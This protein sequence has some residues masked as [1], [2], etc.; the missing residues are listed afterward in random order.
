MKRFIYAFLLACLP[1]I[2]HA[3]KMTPVEFNDRLAS[4]T[5][6][7]YSIGKEWGTAL[8]TYSTTGKFSELTPYRKKM[9][10]YLDRQITYVKS[11]QDVSNSKDLRMGMITFL[12]YEKGMVTGAFTGFEKL[13]DKS[14]QEQLN[15]ALEKLTDASKNEDAELKKFVDL[16]RA[17]AKANDFVIEDETAK[18]QN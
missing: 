13:T 8:T 6:T 5:D 11:M 17:Y 15:A 3:Q 10:Q 4:I 2:S 18:E 1:A 9:E 16:Q 7:L 12:Q 14:T